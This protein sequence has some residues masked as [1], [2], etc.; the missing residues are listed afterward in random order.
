MNGFAWSYLAEEFC[1]DELLSLSYNG[2]VLE[3]VERFGQDR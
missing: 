2:I 3:G 1:D